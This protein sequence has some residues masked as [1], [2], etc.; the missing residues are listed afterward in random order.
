MPT[1]NRKELAPKRIRGEAN[2]DERM[3]EMMDAAGVAKE[4]SNQTMN[5]EMRD[6]T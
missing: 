2:L 5:S 4:I 6:K 3:E 1:R